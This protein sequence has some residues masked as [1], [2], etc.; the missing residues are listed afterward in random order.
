MVYEVVPKLSSVMMDLTRHDR[1]KFNS[2]SCFVYS[3]VP[4]PDPLSVHAVTSVFTAI[5]VA[6][7]VRSTL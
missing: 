2:F 1:T 5:S 3:T 4:A 6:L 7:N